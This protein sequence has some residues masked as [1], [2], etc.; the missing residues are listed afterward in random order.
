MHTYINNK[1]INRRKA[2]ALVMWLPG[3]PKWFP[4]INRLLQQSQVKK[5][6]AVP[7]EPSTQ[8]I[9]LSDKITSKCLHLST[10][11]WNQEVWRF[12]ALTL[13]YCFSKSTS[14]PFS[15][16][17]SVSRDPGAEWGSL[18]CWIKDYSVIHIQSWGPTKCQRVFSLDTHEH[19]SWTPTFQMFKTHFRAKEIHLFSW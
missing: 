13:F 7:F 10:L 8:T 16:L 12:S 5:K 6:L 4:H 15:L 17:P 14:L 2:S 18:E 1:H 11:R 3:A 19:S 9:I